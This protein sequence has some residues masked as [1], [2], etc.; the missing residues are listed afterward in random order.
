MNEINELK[1]KYTDEELIAMSVENI[2][3]TLKTLENTS[4]LNFSHSEHVKNITNEKGEIS[5]DTA[6][7]L[8]LTTKTLRKDVERL[9][10]HGKQV[11]W[12][13]EKWDET[14]YSSITDFLL[15]KYYKARTKVKQKL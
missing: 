15:K 12:V 8:A 7:K 9:I 6:A 14:P 11:E 13:V 10:S 4:L 3:A 2:A 5:T 1:Q